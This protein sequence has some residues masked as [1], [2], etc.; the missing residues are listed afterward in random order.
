MLLMFGSFSPRIYGS[1]HHPY[2][3]SQQFLGSA[4]ERGV[5]EAAGI[6]IDVQQAHFV[7]P[8]NILIHRC[9]ITINDKTIITIGV[10]NV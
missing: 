1:Q 3:F 2:T 6:G 9:R 5:R 8:S 4:E 7:F 10:P